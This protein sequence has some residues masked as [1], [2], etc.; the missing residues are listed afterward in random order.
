MVPER[1]EGESAWRW[2]EEDIIEIKIKA[3][4]RRNEALNSNSK[5]QILL[6]G[7]FS[8]DNLQNIIFQKILLSYL[9]FWH[10]C[11]NP[12]LADVMLNK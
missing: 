11:N 9:N 5:C 3:T 4:E 12:L 7:W 10:E 2:R 6:P 1:T 8:S